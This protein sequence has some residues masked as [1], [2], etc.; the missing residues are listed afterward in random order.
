MLTRPLRLTAYFVKTIEPIYVIF[1][2]IQ[3]GIV[4]RMSV[5]S[6]LNKYII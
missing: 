2:A 3:H 1:G 5:K 4:L 6:I